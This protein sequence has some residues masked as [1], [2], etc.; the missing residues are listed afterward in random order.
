M[1]TTVE[2]VREID[3]RMRQGESFASIEDDVIDPSGLSEDQKSA[4]WLYGWSFVDSRRQ[5][6][7]ASAHLARLAAG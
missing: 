6:R 3:E 7:E 1:A 2:L 5:R 4:L